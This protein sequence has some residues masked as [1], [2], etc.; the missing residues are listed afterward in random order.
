[1]ARF[2]FELEPLLEQ[3]RREERDRMKRVAEVER[4]RVEIEQEAAALAQA[5]HDEQDAL[6]RELGEGGGV[7][8][9]R[10][11]L[12]S[13]ASLHGLRKRHEL[14]LRGAAMLKRLDAA[15]REL[16]EATT[17][18]RAVELLRERRYEAW[19]AAKRTK[20]SREVDELV[21]A[22][23]GRPGSGDGAAA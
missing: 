11:R 19:V 14:A 17:R 3:R 8:L 16:L 23:F 21:T 1:M 9:G 15:R 6:R 10:V 20:E 22:R 2:V 7:D 18:R 12:Q 5:F 13:N 4:D